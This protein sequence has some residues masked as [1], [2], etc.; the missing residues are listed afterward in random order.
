MH[1]LNLLSSLRF[2]RLLAI[3]YNTDAEAVDLTYELGETEYTNL[4]NDEFMFLYTVHLRTQVLAE[5]DEE[6]I[7]A[8]ITMRVG[9]VDATR[10]AAVYTNL[11]FA[12]SVS[13]DW[14]KRGTVTSA[15]N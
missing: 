11:S 4:T 6:D 9:S 14:R 1:Q 7:M 12:T 15:K 3:I 10:H 8:L 2:F 5:E 13:V